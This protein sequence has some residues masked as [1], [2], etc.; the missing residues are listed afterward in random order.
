MVLLGLG[1]NIGERQ[2]YLRAALVGIARIMGGMRLSRVLESTPL[3]PDEPQPGMEVSYLNMVV[4]GDCALSPAAVL[5]ELKSIE[6]ALGRVER[7]RWAPREIDID[8]LA[9]DGL[10]CSDNALVIP[11]TEMLNRDFVMVPLNDVAPEWRYPAPGE[12][13]GKSPAEIITAKGYGICADL[14]ETG[15]CFDV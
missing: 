12:F 7:C 4:R 10:V 3:L 1:S 5:A 6:Q 11:H 8:I 2:E 9:M 14:R 15:L 13:F